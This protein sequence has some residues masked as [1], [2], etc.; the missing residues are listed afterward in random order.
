MADEIIVPIRIPI[1]ELKKALGEA[2]KATE[3]SVSGMEESF[4]K[5]KGAIAAAIAVFA[6]AKFLDV[7]IKAAGEADQAV[8]RLNVALATTGEFSKQASQDIQDYATELEDLTG[9]SDEAVLGAFSLAKSFGLTNAEAKDLTTTAVNL[10]ALT[11]DDLD[12]S[13]RQLA[14]TYSG[15]IGKLGKF[16]SELKNLTDVQLKSG[17]AIKILNE[18]LQDTASNLS[19]TFEGSVKK[20]GTQF[21]N[22]FENF[23]K[24]ITQNKV[25]VESINSIAKIFNELSKDITNNGPAITD[26]VS[27]IAKVIV[28]L[29]PVTVA[30]LSAF[31]TLFGQFAEG[32]TKI[33][34]LVL[35]QLQSVASAFA[36]P[37][38]KNDKLEALNQTIEETAAFGDKLTVGFAK[39]GAAIDLL[40]VQ[41][42][43]L[44]DHIDGI[45]DSA[46]AA[47]KDV[48]NFGTAAD[49]FAA[50]VKKLNE[51]IAGNTGNAIEK[52]ATKAGLL[53]QRISDLEILGALESKKAYELRLK[54]IND[55]NDKATKEFQD[56]AEKRAKAEEHFQN[57]I[58]EAQKNAKAASSELRANPFSNPKDE[59]LLTTAES[60]GSR[61]AGVFADALKGKQGALNLVEKAADAII[62]GAGE[63]VGLLSQGKDVVKEQIKSF[64]DA[65]PDIIITVTEALPEA[66]VTLLEKV[67]TAEFITKLAV[68]LAKIIPTI[69]IGLVKG[70]LQGLATFASEIG[71]QIADGFIAPVS[72]FFSGLG[73][74]FANIFSGLGDI[75]SGVFSGIGS[76]FTNI[77]A[78]AGASISE[79]IRSAFQAY[80]NVFANIG[81]F[82]VEGFTRAKDILFQPINVLIDFLDKFKFPDIG[83]GAGDFLGKIGL[84]EGGIVPKYAADGLFTPR[85]TDTVPAMLTPGELVVPRDTTAQLAGFL[86]DQ[87]SGGSSG[88]NDAL[89]AQILDAVSKPMTVQSSVDFNQSTLADIMLQLSRNNAR[90]AA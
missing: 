43:K 47:T 48:N 18:R 38:V 72:E 76:S 1:D 87:N 40:G 52:E 83:G 20:L 51:D 45:S 26:A 84:A 62:P 75:F 74:S 22:L 3:K 80:I 16:G 55:F 57:T 69:V 13:V 36:L 28:D 24:S 60:F 14:A 78:N 30:G 63:I 67:L 50:D 66:I 19:Q 73:D 34:L 53:L 42:A 21:N 64:A 2:E 61:A 81:N 85:G 8:Q 71:G 29:I 77:F 70:L 33:A 32:I 7:A 59:N 4:N 39:S 23:G 44:S 12:S 15:A 86:K 89:L 54:V 27:K 37:G 58:D 6:G 35:T 79:G 82:I 31:N 65:L 46:K 11:G 49:K 56:A 17:D 68:A 41:A 5:L 25:V 88:N 9:I 10:S 90:T